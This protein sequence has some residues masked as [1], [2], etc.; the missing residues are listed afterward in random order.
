M[1]YII[2]VIFCM[3]FMVSDNYA[4]PGWQRGE[5][6]NVRPERLEQFRR[7][8]LI[9]LLKMN[10]EQA[11]R[12]T[13]KQRAHEEKV[14]DLMVNRNSVLDEIENMVDSTFEDKQLYKLA[15]KILSIDNDIYKER[16]RFYDE[17]KQFLAPTQ[18]GQFLVFERN[19]GRKV[20]DAL[21]EMSRNRGNHPKD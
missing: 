11:V 8:R 17:M 5:Q 7:M 3:I 15:D 9:E 18:F 12:F 10:E 13:T 14:R 6:R 1:K 4:Q 21:D 20:R 2:S 16:Q 19:F